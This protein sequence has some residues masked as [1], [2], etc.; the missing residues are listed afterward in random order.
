[1]L[2]DARAA[3]PQSG[4]NGASIVYQATADGYETR[5][6]L[7]FGEG[8]SSKIGPVRSA[9]FYLDPVGVRGR[10]RPSPTT[11]VTLRTLEYLAQR[12]R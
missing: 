9:R 11:A 12:R 3:R 8:E 10:C 6:L 1:M 2:D 4:F 7:I 5:Y